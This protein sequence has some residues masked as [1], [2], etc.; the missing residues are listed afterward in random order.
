MREWKAWDVARATLE[1]PCSSNIAMAAFT[2][3]VSPAMTVIFG[4]FLLAAMT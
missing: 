3:S 1:N 2:G 4:E